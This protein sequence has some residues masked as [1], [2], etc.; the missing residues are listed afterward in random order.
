VRVLC[1]GNMYPPHHLGG[2]ELV[3]R[4]A[5]GGLRERGH[6]VRVL[7]TDHRQAGAVGDDDP[8]VRRELRWYWRDHGFPRRSARERRDIEAHNA[9]VFDAALDD[10]SPDAVT[11]WSMGGMSLSL[12][13]R[14]ARAGLPAAAFVHDDWLL[15]APRVDGSS[16]LSRRRRRRRVAQAVDSW[17]FVSEDVRRRAVAEGYRL[18]R[19]QIAPSGISRRFL[20]PGPEREWGWRLLYVGRIDSRKGV[21]TAVDALA[22]LPDE[23]SLTIVGEGDPAHAEQLR[24]HVARAG[25][26]ERVRLLGAREPDELPAIYDDHDA[27]LFP[28]RWNEP[29]GLVPLEAMARGRPVIATGR[30]GSGEYLREGENCLLVEAEAPEAV[31]AATRRLAVDPQL[32]ARLRAG[33]LETA[34]RHTEYG[35]NATVVAAVEELGERR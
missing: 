35:F 30:G 19:A 10:F 28:V 20:G 16:R 21:D 7:T 18:R 1:V 13:E 15:Y 31:A 34:A 2:Y 17:W 4:A 24:E 32:R 6:E 14:A 23:A 5:V 29:W 12:I 8:D 33:G 27:V 3:W 9:R 11:W 25:L 26:S 22:G